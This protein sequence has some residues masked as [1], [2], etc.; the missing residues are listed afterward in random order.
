MRNAKRTLSPPSSV[1]FEGEMNTQAQCVCVAQR[2]GFARHLGRLSSGIRAIALVVALDL[3]L[4]PRSKKEPGV[5]TERGQG[6]QKVQSKGC[7]TPCKISK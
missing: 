1:C 3:G 5:E 6:K 4:F 2:G 7:R